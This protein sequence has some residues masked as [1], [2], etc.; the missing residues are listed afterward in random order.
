[1]VEIET[2]MDDCQSETNCCILRK[3]MQHMQQ[4]KD[5]DDIN[6]I[7]NISSYVVDILNLFLHAID[8][9]NLDQQFKSTFDKLVQC[10]IRKCSAFQRNNRNR[11]KLE[12]KQTLNAFSSIFDKIHCYYYHAYDIGNRIYAKE[13]MN[14]D[15]KK[16][17]ETFMCSNITNIHHILKQK[18]K[19]FKTIYDSFSE[20][21]HQKYNQLFMQNDKM[22]S[23]GYSFEY[24]QLQYH[25]LDQQSPIT[26]KSVYASLKEELINNKSI[27]LSLLQFINEYNKAKLHL[28]TTFCKS[29]YHKLS[30][31]NLLSLM[32]YCNFTELQYLF[33]KTYRENNGED[34]R[35]FY[36]LGH[37]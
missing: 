19:K 31:Q 13:Q 14:T 33:S 22:Y 35:H 37:N 2:K 3:L 6:S 27:S 12:S 8:Q 18:R 9:H 36:H 4:Y 34:H 7:D 16:Q 30:I 28:K 32:I 25:G 1:M 26:I 5:N 29:K 23:F 20:K 11:F 24:D 10:D 21:M 15:E 17:N